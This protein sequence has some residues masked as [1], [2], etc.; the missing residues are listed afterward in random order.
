MDPSVVRQRLASTA[1][2]LQRLAAVLVQAEHGPQRDAIARTR[3]ALTQETEHLLGLR[4]RL[5][6]AERKDT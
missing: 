1:S 3:I 5:I 4:A 6:D 2:V